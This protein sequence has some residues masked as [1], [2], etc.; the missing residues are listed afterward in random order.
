M[1]NSPRFDAKVQQLFYP[2]YAHNNTYGIQVT[3]DSSYQGIVKAYYG[4]DGCGTLLPNC[5]ALAAKDDPESFGTSADVRNSC[6]HVLNVCENVYGGFGIFTDVRLEMKFNKFEHLIRLM[7]TDDIQIQRSKTDIAHKGPDPFPTPY[8]IGY[9]NSAP[10]Q[11]ALGVPLNF[12][13]DSTAVDGG[14]ADTA[15]QILGGT[16]DDLGYLLDQGV[17]VALVY[18]DRDYSYNCKAQSSISSA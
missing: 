18:G 8:H 5:Q 1:L 2:T 7:L 4:E 9:L 17:K 11:L 10:V 14:F 6:G 15:D 3:D 12:T 16:L 13:D